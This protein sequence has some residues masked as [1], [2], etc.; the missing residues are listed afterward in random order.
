V[1]GRGRIGAA[2][3]V[4][5]DAIVGCQIAMMLLSIDAVLEPGGDAT[6]CDGGNIKIMSNVILLA[7]SLGAVFQAGQ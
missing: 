3:E 2:V 6:E 7:S 5:V 1:A 4:E